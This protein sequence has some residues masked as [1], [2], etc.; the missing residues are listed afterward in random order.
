LLFHKARSGLLTI[1]LSL[2]FTENLK[3]SFADQIALIPKVRLFRSPFRIGLMKARML[4]AANSKGPSL[5]F[6]DAH[7]EVT[8][9]WLEPLLDRLAI[10]RNIT[11]LSVVNS[12]DL[13]T[14]AVRTVSKDLKIQITGFSW[15][16]MFTWIQ[17]PDKQKTERK[18]HADPI[19]SPTMLGAFFGYILM[20]NFENLFNIFCIFSD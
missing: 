16:L 14:L 9:G 11:A 15:N 6:M 3:Q 2:Y 18:S 13:K 12:L 17:M 19:P 10:N 1:N 4:G 5:I 7:I 20:K 8:P